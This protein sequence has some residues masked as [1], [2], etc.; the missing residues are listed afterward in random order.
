[1]LEQEAVLQ[2]RVE[3]LTLDPV[4]LERSEE[5][6]E[7]LHRVR[8]ALEGGVPGTHRGR[9]DERQ[10]DGDKGGSGH[11]K[12]NMKQCIHLQDFY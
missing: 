2:Q 9:R 11:G 5:P 10:R 1:M 8:D 6:E 7:S 12:G 3:P 4:R